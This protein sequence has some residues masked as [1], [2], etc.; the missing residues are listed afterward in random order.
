[1]FIDIGN[2]KESYSDP[3]KGELLIFINI[4]FTLWVYYYDGI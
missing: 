3:N 1:M 4:R 2:S